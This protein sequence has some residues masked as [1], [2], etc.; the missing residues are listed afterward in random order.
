M[1][2][3]VVRTKACAHDEAASDDRISCWSNVVLCAQP[4]HDLLLDLELIYHIAAKPHRSSVP[5]L[6]RALDCDDH[7]PQ[8]AQDYN[9]THDPFAYFQS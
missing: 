5:L 9:N 3:C 4:C 7:L 1:D 6:K 8:A 2:G